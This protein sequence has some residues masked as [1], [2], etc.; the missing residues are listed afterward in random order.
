MVFGTI[1]T[2]GNENIPAEENTEKIEAEPTNDGQELQE[3]PS[4]DSSEKENAE[5]NQNQK[6][7]EPNMVT[8][9]RTKAENFLIALAECL[10][11]VQTQKEMVDKLVEVQQGGLENFKKDTITK[12]NAIIEATTD[13]KDK[14]VVAGNYQD[15]LAEQVKNANLQKDVVM[16]QQQLDKEKAEISQFLIK[17]DSFLTLRIG[18]LETKVNELRNADEIIEN[19][20]KKF[21]EE[22]KQETAKHVASAENIVETSSNSLVEGAKNQMAGLRAECNE[23]LKKYTEKCQAHLE[24]VKKQSIDFLKQCENENKKLIEKVPAVANTK[25]SKKD[26]V[27]YV[28]AGVSI[29]SLLVQMLV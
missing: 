9:D 29:A 26:L 23:M 18:V 7:K 5:E 11:N 3:K 16:L 6:T 17:V 25:I 27:I 13:L 15:Y 19:N 10:E 12:F 28:M 24:T 21:K 4:Q 8:I 1:K 14:I 22:L 20:I 2:Q